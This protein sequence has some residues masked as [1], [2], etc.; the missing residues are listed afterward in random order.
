MADFEFET[1]GLVNVTNGSVDVI[2]VGTNWVASY[3]GLMLWLDGLSYPVKSVNGRNSITLVHPYQG[4]TATGAKYALVPVHP[5]TL[6]AQKAVITVLEAINNLIA[7][8]GI[9]GGGG[10]TGSGGPG[11]IGAVVNSAGHLIITLSDGR[12]ID[13][14][15]V[16]GADGQ[17]GQDGTGSGGGDISMA[18]IQGFSQFAGTPVGGGLAGLFIPVTT[19]APN[20]TL[21]QRSEIVIPWDDKDAGAAMWVEKRPNAAAIIVGAANVPLPQPGGDEVNRR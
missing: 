20:I 19:G 11:I 16:K 3:P 8:G 12:T 7:N 15:L 17:D 10:G 6:N 9:G 2:G 21:T 14:G 4:S 1:T 5:G 18:A 13:A